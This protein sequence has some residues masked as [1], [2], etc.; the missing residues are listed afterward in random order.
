MK[1]FLITYR[2]GGKEFSV[3]VGGATEREARATFK[4]NYPGAFIQSVKLLR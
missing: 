2:Q 1:R 3:P 4:H